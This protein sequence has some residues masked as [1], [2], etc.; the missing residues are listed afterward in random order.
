MPP[1]PPVEGARRKATC[2]GGT[3][4]RASILPTFARSRLVRVPVR[5]RKGHS[6]KDWIYQVSRMNRVFHIFSSSDRD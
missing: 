6:M 3:G 1:K 4:Y 2:L 5:Q